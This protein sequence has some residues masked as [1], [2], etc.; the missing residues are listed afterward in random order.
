MVDS[1]MTNMYNFSMRLFV[2]VIFAVLLLSPSIISATENFGIYQL[3]V[4]SM[5]FDN[6]FLDGD[7]IK[8]SHFPA[9]FNILYYLSDKGCIDSIQCDSPDTNKFIGGVYSSLKN[10]DF[11]PAKYNDSAISIILPA[12]L[13]FFTPRY[14]TMVR[15]NFPYNHA[16]NS[17]RYELVEDFLELNGFRPAAVNIIPPYY[18]KLGNNFNNANYPFATFRIAINETGKLTKIETICTNSEQ[19]ADLLSTVLLYAGYDAASYNNS[20][21]NSDLFV[22]VRFFKQ[23]PYPT[24]YW[25]PVFSEN[26]DKIDYSYDYHRISFRPYLDSIINPPMPANLISGGIMVNGDVWFNDSLFADVT[27]DTLGLIKSSRYDHFLPPIVNE[28][29]KE[30]IKNLRFLPAYDIHGDRAEYEGRIKLIFEN[31]SKNI[32]V[33]SEWLLE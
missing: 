16:E 31:N 14:Q 6:W 15:L 4:P 18:C 30:V 13:E 20:P 5:L 7:K 9:S 1:K 32:R 17:F 26:E 2:G 3:D 11:S 25:P 12:K 28:R 27:I 29:T 23:I 8:Y 33:I 10:I 21:I 24:D 22:T 19:H